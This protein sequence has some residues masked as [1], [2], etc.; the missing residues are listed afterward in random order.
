MSRDMNE[1]AMGLSICLGM[2][3]IGT[4]VMLGLSGNLP[5][6][7]NWFKSCNTIVG[8][9]CSQIHPASATGTCEYCGEQL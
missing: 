8:G 1:I 2:V 7:H 6:N 4:M 5:S 9:E 3:V